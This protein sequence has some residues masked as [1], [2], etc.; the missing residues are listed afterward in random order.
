VLSAKN[1]LLFGSVR[2]APQTNREMIVNKS[3]QFINK[4]NKIVLPSYLFP[5]LSV[6]SHA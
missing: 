2:I 4:R 6:E 3:Q 5:E 1:T